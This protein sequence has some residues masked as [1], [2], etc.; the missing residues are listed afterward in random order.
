MKNRFTFRIGKKVDRISTEWARSH[1]QEGKEKLKEIKNCNS[2][3]EPMTKIM[4]FFSKTNIG[5]LKK[6]THATKRHNQKQRGKVERK[7]AKPIVL[8]L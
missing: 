1:F 6:K 3:L 4:F 7:A 2:K 8:F 5:N